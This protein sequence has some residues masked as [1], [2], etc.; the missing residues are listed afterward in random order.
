MTKDGRDGRDHVNGL[1]E[2]LF[3]CRERC[4]ILT[5]LLTTHDVGFYIIEN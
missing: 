5:E 2:Q 4:I 3:S 1:D